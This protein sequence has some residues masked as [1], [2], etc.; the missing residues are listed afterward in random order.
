MGQK[1]KDARVSALSSLGKLQRQAGAGERQLGHWYGWRG[2][3]AGSGLSIAP[4]WHSASY[5]PC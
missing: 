1:N 2:A 4:P 3:C 5:H